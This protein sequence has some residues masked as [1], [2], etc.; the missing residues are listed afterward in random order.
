MSYDSTLWRVPQLLGTVLGYLESNQRWLLMSSSKIPEDTEEIIW[1][2]LYHSKFGR[3]VGKSL[4]QIAGNWRDIFLVRSC[5]DSGGFGII[6]PKKMNKACLSGIP[7]SME[8]MT[9]LQDIIRKRS[10]F[11]VV[12]LLLSH[13]RP[14]LQSLSANDLV[15]LMEMAMQRGRIDIFET[16]MKNV[17]V[18]QATLE[19]PVPKDSWV[20]HWLQLLGLYAWPFCYCCLRFASVAF[21]I[22]LAPMRLRFDALSVASLT[23]ALT[24]HRLW[25][26]QA[27]RKL[28][29]EG[30][31]INRQAQIDVRARHSRASLVPRYP[32]ERNV[33]CWLTILDVMDLKLHFAREKSREDKSC[34]ALLQHETCLRDG[35]VELGALHVHGVTDVVSPEFLKK[36]CGVIDMLHP[37]SPYD[38]A[39]QSQGPIQWMRWDG[40]DGSHL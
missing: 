38:A 18:A 16:A 24:Q 10:S 19:I 31:D 36:R 14:Q 13:D 12:E 8:E 4:M 32:Q 6:Q 15:L 28:V 34:E 3:R 29:D 5:M 17:A 21:K 35:L 9:L 22:L 11:R 39:A 30:L 1:Q 37:S 2:G 23:T 26:L 20:K 40:M 27:L 25:Q 7:A 33:T